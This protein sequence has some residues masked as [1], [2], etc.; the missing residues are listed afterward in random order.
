MMWVVFIP[1]YVQFKLILNI[2]G[3][4]CPEP[5]NYPLDVILLDCMIMSLIV[6]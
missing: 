4:Q 6:K 3:V 2:Y 5:L 1:V